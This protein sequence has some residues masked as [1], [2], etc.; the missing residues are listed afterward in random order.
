[1]DLI[2]I[3]KALISVSD[4][5]N[6]DK[7]L[8]TLQEYNVEIL[9]TGGTFKYIKDLGYQCT[10]VSDYTKSQEILDGRVKT[11][12]PKI[13]GGLLAK[14]DN[15]EHINQISKENTDLI[16]LLI[17]NLYPF[18][19]KLLEDANEEILVENIDIGGPSM[20]RAAAKNYK[21]ATVISDPDQYDECINELNK[22]QGSTSLNFRK[23]MS[24]NAFLETAYYDSIIS[25]WMNKE[26]SKFPKKITISGS[27]QN[28]LRYGE[29]PHQQASVYN[30]NYKKD[31]LYG[32]NQLQGKE[33]SYNNYL[34]M[35]AAI[36][37][38]KYLDNT[39][40]ICVIVKHNNPCGCAVS[41]NLSNA[42][43]LALDA[44]PIS[45]FGGVVCFND[46]IN[47][48]LSEKLSNTFY[49]IIISNK[50]TKEALDVFKKKKNIRLII[51]KNYKEERLTY[52]IIGEKILIQD[53]DIKDL[54]DK[55][56]RVVTK[57]KPTKRQ[58]ADLKFAF[59]I[60]KF[61]KSNAIVIAKNSQT[62]GIGSGQTNR[63]ASSKIACQNAKL[64]FKNEVKNSVAASDAFFPFA[65]GLKELIKLGIKSI[66]QPGGS[67]KDYE[68]IKAANKAKIS[69]IFTGIRN[70]KH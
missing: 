32:I 58:I 67:L 55:D 14:A 47:K 18:E 35:Y 12:H 23:K 37:I 69:M 16:N 5:K 48:E 29:N 46:E 68:V 24:T 56:L 59:N 43:K 27:I 53:K 57:I 63:L 70:F 34:D 17:V 49:E 26:R 15:K 66:I 51:N 6:L 3:K 62:L 36:S 9:S 25:N 50:F 11:L 28:E 52:N 30:I 22:N 65:D 54:Q 39:K 44:D 45:A 38:S 19:K 2:K 4:K 33:L 13:Y 1:M 42:Y 40:K 10:E 21:F 41:N 20:L 64:F 31:L 8:M 7:I 61:V 60:C